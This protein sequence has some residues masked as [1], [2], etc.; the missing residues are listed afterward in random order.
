MSLDT[1]IKRAQLNRV[2]HSVR[3]SQ[4]VLQYG[5]GAMVDFPDQ[6]LMTAAPEYWEDKV[7]QIHD[8]RLEKALH[9]DYFGM[10]GGSDEPQFREGISY[11]RFPEWYF[12]PKCRKFQPI[13]S[14]VDDYKNRASRRQLDSD[15]DMVKR[16]RCPTCGQGLVVAR[17]VTVYENGHIDD[18]P[19]VK[20]VHCQNVGGAKPVCEHPSLTFKTSASS[21]EGLEG[22]TITCESCHA[23]ATLKDAF[24]QGQLEEIDR[25]N[26][27]QYDFTCTGRHPWKNKKESC[28]CYPRVVQRGSSSV[29]FPVVASSLVI[30]P[31]SSLLTKKIE[32]S[33]AFSE[34]KTTI[35]NFI[36]TMT[37]MKALTSEVRTKF[38]E[39]TIQNYSQKIGLEIGRVEVSQV[40]SVLERKWLTPSDEEYSTT[41]IRYRAEEYEALSGEVV[42]KSDE[43]DDFLREGTDI[44]EYAIP[45]VKQ[46][47]LIHKIREVQALTGFS[48]LSPVEQPDDLEETSHFVS[49]KEENTK[50]YP[51]Y[52]VR[53]EGIF[54][55]FDNDLIE[56]WSSNNIELERRMEILNENYRRSFIGG[57]KPRKITGKFLLL[58]TI[59][60][61]LIKQLSFECG[62]SIASLKERIYCSDESDGK[63]MAGLLIYTASGDSE[64]TMGGLVRQGR[65]D[66]FPH[67]FKKAIESALTCSNDPVCSLSS[68]QGRDSLNLASCYSCSLIPET[69][70]EE[71]N[72]F[73]DRG[74]VVG[75]CENHELGFFYKYLYGAVD[76]N[77]TIDVTDK[78]EK[79]N[80]SSTGICI[81][82]KGTDLVDMPYSEI[83]GSVRQWSGSENEKSLMDSIE[84]QME[85]QQKY[86]KPFKDAEFRNIYSE[87]IY[88][89]DLFWDKS[90]VAYFT[91]DNEEAYLMAKEHSVWQCFYGGD[92]SLQIK[93]LLSAIEEN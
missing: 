45:F 51:A 1:N 49:V 65:A 83:W 50:W 42:M 46:I 53:G 78:L 67:I 71:F 52:E 81:V 89:C 23:K 12:C 15:P 16:M 54:I 40:K 31:Y 82:N 34:C 24:R 35:S 7:I 69:S 88:T 60:H 32:K 75:T 8:E 19:W 26:N 5:V 90:K 43:Y 14:W 87:E 22:L 85:P 10:P 80:T 29:Y 57:N 86:E 58:H 6:T 39:G 36:S 55:E 47:S 27:Y 9:V 20:W 21:A 11:A 61:L 38:I 79:K 93:N 28:S 3:A 56:H 62:Y 70:C 92:L 72:I 77:C 76:W 13:K 73:L 2:T 74:V 84:N 64:G 59:S 30:P 63:V 48:R 25:K 91:E 4:A 18:F 68:G 66:T 44:T 17:I 33:L 41:S 37:N